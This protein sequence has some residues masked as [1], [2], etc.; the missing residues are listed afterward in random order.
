M[1]VA[2]APVQAQ[3]IGDFL[4]ADEQPVLAAAGHEF[5][6]GLPIP[7]PIFAGWSFSPGVRRH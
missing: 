6:F 3:E 1:A 5:R 2:G 4:D 7:V